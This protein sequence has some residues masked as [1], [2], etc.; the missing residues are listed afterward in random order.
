MQRQKPLK[1]P[2]VIAYIRLSVNYRV[3]QRKNENANRQDG[4]FLWRY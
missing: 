1:F 2:S 4:V 3:V